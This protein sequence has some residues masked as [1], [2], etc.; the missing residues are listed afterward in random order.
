[1]LALRNQRVDRAEQDGRHL[2]RNGNRATVTD[3]D[4]RAGELVVQL[5]TGPTVRLPADYLADGHVDHGYVMTIHKAQGMTTGRT[6]VL[7]SPDL[8]RELGYVAASRHTDEAH[9]YVNV[10]ATDD[11]Q[12]G[13]PA[14]EDR[15]LYGVLERGLGTER[16]KHLVLDETEIDTKLGELST[17]ELLEIQDRGRTLLTSIPRQARR[18]REA[19]LIERAAGHLTRLQE[20][21]DNAQAELEQLSDRRR[22]RQRR[23]ELERLTDNLDRAIENNRQELAERTDQAADFDLDQWLADNELEV[24]EAAAADRELAARRADAYWR[25]TRTVSLDIDPEIERQLGERPENPPTVKSGSA[26]PLPKSPTPSSTDSSPTPTSPTPPRSPAGS[27]MTSSRRTTSL[28]SSS[29]HRPPISTST[30]TSGRSRRDQSTA[31]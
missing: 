12:P 31:G 21:R 11:L 10:P 14:P 24:V 3:I 19:E 17:A 15:D 30:P 18:A 27:S 4:H 26:Q 28:R 22:D 23:A 1:M 6:F 7:A 2:L 9:F 13:E 20:L 16:A 29:P 25:A 8:A 5:D